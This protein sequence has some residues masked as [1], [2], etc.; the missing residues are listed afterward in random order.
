MTLR[1]SGTP[2]LSRSGTGPD[3]RPL[4]RLSAAARGGQPLAFDEMLLP[5]TDQGRGLREYVSMVLERKWL[6]LVFIALGIGI[7]A[8]QSMGKPTYYIATAAIT[9]IDDREKYLYTPSRLSDPTLEY[10]RTYILY[11][12]KTMAEVMKSMAVREA[13]ARHMASA[14]SLGKEDRSRGPGLPSGPKRGQIYPWAVPRA[15]VVPQAK[16]QSITIT[17]SSLQRDMALGAMEGYLSVFKEQ[18][19]L[20]KHGDAVKALAWLKNGLAKAREEL[21]KSQ[22]ALQQFRKQHGMLSRDRRS[23]LAKRL[24]TGWMDQLERPDL[25]RSEIESS[26][27]PQEQERKRPQRHGTVPPYLATLQKRI[28]ALQTQYEDLQGIYA[29]TYPSVVVMRKKIGLLQSMLA[30]L[31]QRET[32]ERGA[33][34]QA[35][36]ELNRKAR[37][38]AWNEIVKLNAAGPE[39]RLLQ[40]DVETNKRIYELM[41]EE[42]KKGRAPSRS[43]RGRLPD[44]QPSFGLRNPTFVFEETRPRWADRSVFRSGSR[45]DDRLHGHERPLRE[46]HR[47]GTLAARHS[48]LYPIFPLTPSQSL[49]RDMANLMSSN[50][51]RMMTRTRPFSSP[52]EIFCR[53]CSFRVWVA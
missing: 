30:E 50:Y 22:D 10:F 25:S 33:D 1:H 43:G 40:M 5:P 28:A 32:A 35:Q 15:S 26:P 51:L 36:E 47:P 46:R 18:F 42:Y 8:K 21:S 48:A 2:D 52:S 45:A 41:F 3:S 24:A 44:R 53:L 27:L 13:V 34:A 17:T 7:A 12:T 31:G 49:S 23:D 19:Q 39:F 20:K 29:P 37:E 4:G 11:R 6:V 9:M 14:S 38:D 16:G